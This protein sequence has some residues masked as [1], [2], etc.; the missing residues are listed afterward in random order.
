VAVFVAFLRGINVGGHALLRMDALAAMLVGLGHSRVTTLL[1]S[2]NVLFESRARDETALARR[3]ED[4]IEAAHGFRPDVILRRPPDLAAVVAENPFPEEA[5]AQPGR[6]LVV[7]LAA[8]ADAS[9]I[10]RLAAVHRGPERF[11]GDGREL[12]VVYPDGVGRSKLTH[13]LIE[14]AL[15]VRGTARNWNTVVKL[16]DLAAQRAAGR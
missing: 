15:G 10:A 4:A 3:I 1:Q 9:G 7:F 13:A 6:L 5:T 16:S 14:K 12:Y 8:P 2:G 11:V